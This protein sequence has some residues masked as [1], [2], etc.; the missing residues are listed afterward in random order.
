[1]RIASLW[2]TRV[3]S[4]QYSP[5]LWLENRRVSDCFS[6]SY[7]AVTSESHERIVLYHRLREP[8]TSVTRFQRTSPYAH[9]WGCMCISHIHSHIVTYI[10]KYIRI[11]IYNKGLPL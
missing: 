10:Y 11:Y 8:V 6:L 3:A 1:M 5:L 4:W 2:W 7:A 9:R